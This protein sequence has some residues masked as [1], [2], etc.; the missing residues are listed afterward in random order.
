MLAP[1]RG[2]GIRRSAMNGVSRPTKA[3]DP[4]KTRKPG[5]K[6]DGTIDPE[7]VQPV[8]AETNTTFP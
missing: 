8:A 4:P 5:Y 6:A 2:G 1:N 3:G 7:Y